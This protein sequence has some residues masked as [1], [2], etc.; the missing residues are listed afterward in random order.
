MAKIKVA[1]LS[2][3]CILLL[4]S[5]KTY[6][7]K[8]QF[9]IMGFGIVE[10]FTSEGNASCPPA[11]QT[12]IR[13]SKEFAGKPVYLLSFHV[14]YWD[15]K[16]WKDQYS[17]RA[18]TERQRYYNKILHTDAYTPQAVFNGKKEM[19][20]SETDNLRTLIKA[21]LKVFTSNVIS[22]A[23]A[24]SGNQ[25]T[26]NYQ[27]HSVSDDDLV[28]VAIVQEHATDRVTGGE[29]RG[30]T[31]SHVNVVRNFKTVNAKLNGGTQLTI[32]PDLYGI[33]FRIITY[34][35]SK[36]TGE[37]IAGNT[38]VIGSHQVITVRKGQ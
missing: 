5:F 7:D 37:V 38:V 34:I 32:P 26:V 27:L 2:L 23:A 9:L 30:T 13:L 17:D 1:G 22:I 21:S 25:L 14:D 35:Q 31:M 20:G 19:I 24:I 11:D 8:R 16:G 33:P 10:L 15:N 6:P 4:T 29:N 28:N 3:L 36:S 12:L 18:Y